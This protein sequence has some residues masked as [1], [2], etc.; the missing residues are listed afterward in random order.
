MGDAAGMGVKAGVASPKAEKRE[1]PGMGQAVN[2]G[3]SSGP[4]GPS[5]SVAGREGAGAGGGGS[6][7]PA[8]EIRASKGLAEADIQAVSQ[9]IP[10]RRSAR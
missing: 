7:G 3:G 10:R 6:G 9:R 8:P 4:S 2:P 5:G 1:F